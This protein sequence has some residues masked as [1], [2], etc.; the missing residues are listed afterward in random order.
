MQFYYMSILIIR[1]QE[2]K[3]TYHMHIQRIYPNKATHGISSLKT[4]WSQRCLTADQWFSPCIIYGNGDEIVGC[5]LAYF[6][7]N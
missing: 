6:Q 1:I 4:S 3:N 7:I 2:Q 5:N